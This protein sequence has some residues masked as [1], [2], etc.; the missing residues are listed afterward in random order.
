MSTIDD[1]TVFLYFRGNR[2]ISQ[3]NFF[4]FCQCDQIG[5]FLH[6]SSQPKPVYSPHLEALSPAPDVRQPDAGGEG[7][8]L[9]ADHGVDGADDALQLLHLERD[10]VVLGAAIG[11]RVDADAHVA[12]AAKLWRRR[13]KKVMLFHVCML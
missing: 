7:A 4:L 3:H 8:L 13:R 5:L 10:L 6:S 2:R 12:E 11:A 1:I 9:V